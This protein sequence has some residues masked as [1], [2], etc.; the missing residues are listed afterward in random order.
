MLRNAE[1]HLATEFAEFLEYRGLGTFSW[2]GR[3]DPFFDEPARQALKDLYGY[4]GTALRADGI[5]CSFHSKSLIYKISQ[6]HKAIH[7]MNFGPLRS[8][9]QRVPH[10]R[11][12]VL[13]AWFWMRR[14]SRMGPRRL[15][16]ASAGSHSG[17]HPP[18]T[19]WNWPDAK[20]LPYAK[21]VFGERDYYTPL[22]SVL[23]EDSQEGAAQLLA[24][25]RTSLQH[26]CSELDTR[27]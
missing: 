5:R 20:P 22:D 26:V 4:V 8:V 24:F 23:L 19:V 15:G 18:I 9:A 1:H 14:R 17:V 2:G 27:R 16:M 25:V 21:E 6:P 7:L 12:P 3:G 11:G 13:G 10:L